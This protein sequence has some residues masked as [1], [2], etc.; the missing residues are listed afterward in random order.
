[1]YKIFEGETLQ[2]ALFK[3]KIDLGADAVLVEHKVIK[4]GGLL[5]LFAKDVY[6]VKALPSAKIKNN[7][8]QKKSNSQFSQG[9]ESDFDKNAYL[10]KVQAIINEKKRMNGNETNKSSFNHVID[11][12]IM[13]VVKNVSQINQPSIN[14]VY[15]PFPKNERS[16]SITEELKKSDLIK[17]TYNDKKTNSVKQGKNNNRYKNKNIE[18]DLNNNNG[19]NKEIQLLKNELKTI[20]STMGVVLEK[21]KQDELKYP[22][23]LTRFYLFLIEN[24]FEEETAE[25]IIKNVLNK[26]DRNNYD[27]YSLVRYEVGEE[28]KKI[29]QRKN[30]LKADNNS[31]KIF[32][33]IG[34]TGVGKTT[35]L[36]KLGAY[37]TLEEE[38]EI[39]FLTLD[40]YRLAAVDQLKKYAGVLNVPMKV[41]YMPEEINE[42]IMC[43]LKKDLILIDTAGRSP[44]DDIQM[45]ELIDFVN[46]AKFDMEIALTL[47]ATT[48]YS[49][50]VE[51]VEKFSEVKF[52][53]LI[54]TKVDETI[55]LGQIIS[56]ID[57]FNI[58]ISFIATGQDVPDHFEI[59]KPEIFIKLLFKKFEKIGN[60]ELG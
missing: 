7:S 57:K 18:K 17:T 40:T 26:L 5:G 14:N 6:V 30:T 22:G 38:K 25:K 19:L 4:K 29:L 34:P 39:A 35:T 21:I 50:L 2:Q 54:I 28:L 42:S 59:F 9:Q 27:N 58:P 41:V 24:E 37:L 44:F 33:V 51:I 13:P 47:S 36:A 46:A 1:M 15:S 31:I 10:K 16:L 3:M 55:S 32:T 56:I 48:K 43:Y 23:L 45:K 20:S 52:D 60:I 49:D 53:Q 8:K 12:D 11:D